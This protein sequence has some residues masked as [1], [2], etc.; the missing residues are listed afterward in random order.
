[1][2]SISTMS[3]ISRSQNYETLIKIK[4]SVSKN[5]R[6]LGISLD[7][8][9]IS[10]IFSLCAYLLMLLGG[11]AVFNYM[12]GENELIAIK[13]DDQ[14][15]RFHRN[16]IMN[17]V[18]EAVQAGN[19]SN[20]ED[21]VVN[22]E[23]HVIGFQKQ[24][25]TIRMWT[26]TNAL[27]FSF[28]I[29]STIGYGRYAPSTTGGRTFLIIYSIIGIPITAVCLARSAERCLHAFNWLS[30]LRSDKAVKAFNYYDK[31]D[32]GE[33]DLD[34]FKNAMEEFGYKL[35]IHELEKLWHIIDYDG[36]GTLDL[37]EFREVMKMLHIDLT[38][39][40]GK[41]T[42]IRN[43]LVALFVW[44]VIGIFFFSNNEN[45][46]PFISFYFL[47]VSLTTIGLGDFIPSSYSG[48]IFLVFYCAVG[49]GLIAV[50]LTIIERKLLHQAELFQ[51]FKV[52]Y[53]NSKLKKKLKEIPQFSRLSDEKLNTV[54]SHCEVMRYYK[55]EK[56]IEERS[57][58]H[59]I[60]F[61]V[62]GKVSVFRHDRPSEKEEINAGSLL[63]ESMLSNSMIRKS[64]I[65]DAT[66]HAMTKVKFLLV[67]VDSN[68]IERSSMMNRFSSRFHF[69]SV[70]DFDSI[71]AS[72]KQSNE[73]GDN[74]FDKDSTQS[75]VTYNDELK[76]ETEIK[77]PDEKVIWSYGVY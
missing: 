37:E 18:H 1:M 70:Q 74:D 68:Y 40:A 39:A 6:C 4:N 14:A 62:K 77:E 59:K 29:L 15:Y 17:L 27:L 5:I 47:I 16:E 43:T 63:F 49:L 46:S 51:S 32:S 13:Q 56:I 71:D 66:V 54:V 3:D 26:F 22:L 53:L 73:G 72:E 12:E 25:E 67:Y 57:K 41:K 28:T 10:F 36:S 33:L 20:V 8:Q 42:E 30:Q 52:T 2:A 55:D 34:E 64:Y 21:L 48:G 35:T 65:A 44:L 23:E 60:F 61:I 24:E 58:Q 9:T 19:T 76:N 69:S 75:E 38:E 11:A 45:W 50:G 7:K 31:D